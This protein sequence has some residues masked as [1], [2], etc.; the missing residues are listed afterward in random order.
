MFSQSTECYGVCGIDYRKQNKN[1]IENVP[2]G[3]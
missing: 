1:T 3:G 2:W